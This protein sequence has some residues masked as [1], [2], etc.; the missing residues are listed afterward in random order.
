MLDQ[1]KSAARVATIVFGL[2]TMSKIAFVITGLALID[3]G[4]SSRHFIDLE[5]LFILSSLAGVS[6]ITFSLILRRKTVHIARLVSAFLFISSSILLLISFKRTGVDCTADEHFMHCIAVG[7][8]WLVGAFSIA[9]LAVS[10][11][12]IPQ[13]KMDN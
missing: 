13:P 3:L 8:A 7:S 9:S 1:I 12:A 10:A 5:S 6:L 4:L 2:Y 11:T